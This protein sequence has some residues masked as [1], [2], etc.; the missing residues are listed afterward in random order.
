MHVIRLTEFKSSRPSRAKRIRIAA[1]RLR[2][3]ACPATKRVASPTRSPP[4]VRARAMKNA[5]AGLASDQT[6]HPLSEN[7]ASLRVAILATA[8]R[9]V[10]RVCFAPA[11]TKC[12]R[13]RHPPASKIQ[14]AR[15]RVIVTT[16]CGR[17]W[18][19]SARVSM[20]H[21]NKHAPA[22]RSATIGWRKRVPISCVPEK[23]DCVCAANRVLIL[24]PGLGT[25]GTQPIL[26]SRALTVTSAQGQRSLTTAPQAVHASQAPELSFTCVTLSSSLFFLM[27][28]WANLLLL[29]LSLASTQGSVEV[30]YVTNQSPRNQINSIRAGI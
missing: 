16:V 30:V 11:K 15:R 28:F 12:S 8:T 29:F 9:H 18:N 23:M 6:R 22:I 25:A 1:L 21:A 10:L 19:V 4:A 7:V 26:D 5:Q 3:F 24:R 27:N 17:N 2:S 13:V 14:D 20:P